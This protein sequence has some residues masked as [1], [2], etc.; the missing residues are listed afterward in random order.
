MKQ[1][2]YLLTQ[3]YSGYQLHEDLKYLFD[4]PEYLKTLSAAM[5]HEAA[6]TYLNTG[7]YVQVTLFPEKEQEKKDMEEI[8]NWLWQP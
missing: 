1:N 3:I 6:R 5:I 7:N 8:L 4:L 2:N